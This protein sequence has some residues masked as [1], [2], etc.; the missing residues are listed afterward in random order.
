MI[1]IG[2]WKDDAQVV[3]EAISKIYS[4]EQAGI[5]II[6]DKAQPMGAME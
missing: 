1:Y 2:F 3:M 5:F 4:N 6:L